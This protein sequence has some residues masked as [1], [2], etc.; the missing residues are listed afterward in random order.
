[1][2]GEITVAGLSRPLVLAGISTRGILTDLT[3][4]TQLKVRNNEARPG[5]QASGT[6]HILLQKRI[7]FEIC[8]CPHNTL[9]TNT[10]VCQ[11]SDYSPSPW[12]PFVELEKA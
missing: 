12:C 2:L 11:N 5:A 1:M 9:R 7:A 10:I 8:I 4:T 6:S 3:K